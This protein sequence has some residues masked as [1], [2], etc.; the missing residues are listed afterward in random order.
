MSN[1]FGTHFSLDFFNPFLREWSHVAFVSIRMQNKKS[2]HAQDRPYFVQFSMM[3]SVL[4]ARAG[5]IFSVASSTRTHVAQTKHDFGPN[6]FASLASWVDSMAIEPII[7]NRECGA[8]K[9]SDHRPRI[10]CL[11]ANPALSAVVYLQE[12]PTFARDHFHDLLTLYRRGS[13]TRA[14]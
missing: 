9:R 2:I 3:T 13:M 1:S 8:W 5:S 10:L 14:Y 6:H 7:Q 12:I 11:S 4:V